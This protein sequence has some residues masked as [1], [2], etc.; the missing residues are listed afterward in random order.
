MNVGK[1]EDAHIDA[2]ML[3]SVVVPTDVHKASGMR[4]PRHMIWCA[5][6]QRR[7]GTP[8]S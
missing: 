5:S 4:K 6:G 3:V 7:A 8:R 2:D 1:D